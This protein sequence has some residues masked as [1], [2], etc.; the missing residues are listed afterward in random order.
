LEQEGIDYV[1]VIPF[2]KAFSQLSREEFIDNYIVGKLGIKQLIIGYNHHFGRDKAGDHSFL[3]EHGGLEV[4]EI[5]Q[6]RED[7]NKVSS[8]TIREALTRG[9]L[10]LARQLLGHHYTIIGTADDK[11]RVTLDKY[12]LLPADGCYNCT[13]NNNIATCEVSNGELTQ[14]EYFSQKIEILL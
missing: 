2:D 5:A 7:N 11:G 9:D 3:V 1:V 14:R 13:I 4:V 12:K 6:Y 8:T 10:S